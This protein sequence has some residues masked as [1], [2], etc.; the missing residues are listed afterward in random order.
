MTK[1]K[2]EYLTTVSVDP[3]E[4]A[5]LRKS[6]EEAAKILLQIDDLKQALKDISDVEQQDHS[7]AKKFTKTLIALEYDTQYANRKKRGALIENVEQLAELDIL[8]GRKDVE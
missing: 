5:R 6:V 4:R 8:M 2:K 1:I 7:Y 3:K